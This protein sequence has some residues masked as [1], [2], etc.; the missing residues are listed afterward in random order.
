MDEAKQKIINLFYQNVKGKVPD[1][2]GYNANHDGREGQWLEK[3]FGKNPDADNSADFWG[4]EL[5]NETASKTTF[6]DWSANRYIFKDG[7]YANCFRNPTIGTPQDVFCQI[8]GK[9]NPENGGRC[10]WS[11]EPVPHINQYNNFGQIMTVEL[12]PNC[13][14][15]IYYSY[16]K[17]K[18]P[19]KSF[20]VPEALQ[21]ENIE[22]ARWFGIISPSQRRNDKCLREKL[23]NK[24]NQKG[25]FTCKK[26][27]GIYKYICFGEPINYQTWLALVLQ[28]I[29]FFDSGMYQG[30]NRPYQQWR[31]NNSF[32]DSLIKEQ[33]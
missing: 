29:V 21:N 33:Y 2:S 8:F 14:I 26:E 9:P 20:I 7:I 4:Y 31:A 15:V 19:D 30:N 10:S 12:E 16:S 3:Q 18:R 11:G 28:G 1:V 17:D 23:E 13:D 32:W 25:W 24:F 6:G 22:L 5:K 27:D